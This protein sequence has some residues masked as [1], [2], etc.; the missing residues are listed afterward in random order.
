MEQREIRQRLEDSI[1]RIHRVLEDELEDGPRSILEAAHR[2]LT[3]ALNELVTQG[4][5]LG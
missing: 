2:D 5:L 3:A 1:I 4:F